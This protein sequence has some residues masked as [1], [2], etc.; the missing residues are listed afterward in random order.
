VKALPRD[1]LKFAKL[2]QIGFVIDERAGKFWGMRT[3]YSR[4]SP[5]LPEKRLRDYFHFQRSWT[6]FFGLTM[7]N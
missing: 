7:R 2:K 4:I 6:T 5:N 3:F 1:V